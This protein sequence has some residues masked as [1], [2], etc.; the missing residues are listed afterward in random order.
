MR[1]HLGLDTSGPHLAVALADADGTPVARRSDDVGRA[2]ARRIVPTLE[3]LLAD[4]GAARSDLVAVTVGV[5]P[6]SYTGLR[7]GVATAR[8]LA[9]GLGVPLGG[10]SSLAPV[11]WAALAPG[12][13]GVVVR[14][15]RRGQVYA[16]TY[17]RTG[18]ALIERAPAAKRPRD[19]VAAEHA[20]AR[21]LE[22]VAPDA[23]WLATRPPGGA[24]PDPAYL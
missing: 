16:A 23:T 9:L 4:V 12:E 18:D 7:V 20:D 3:A 2:H 10:A 6:G 15:A 8:G 11:A 5:G 24:P 22:D 13:I 17:A 21:W 1:L 19:A 14:D